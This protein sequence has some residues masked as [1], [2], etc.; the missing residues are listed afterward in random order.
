[1]EIIFKSVEDL[2]PYE[3]NPR[4]NADAIDYVAKSIKEFGFRVPIVIDKNNVIITGHT[5]LEAAKKLKMKEVPTVVADDLTEEQVNAYRLADNKVS[6]I[7]DWDYDL[8]LEE[9]QD[10]D[11][12]DLKLFDINDLEIE[13]VDEEES[14]PEEKKDDDYYFKCP[15]CQKLINKEELL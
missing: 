14:K 1:M 3:N 5:R 2:V 4:N 11:L 13:F 8:M 9:I 15:N 10:I 12:D 6:E 7:A